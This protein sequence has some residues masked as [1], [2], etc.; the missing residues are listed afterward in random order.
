LAESGDL[1]SIRDMC[2][3]ERGGA[4]AH[5]G[6]LFQDHI[7][8][9]FCLEMLE[10]SSLREVWCESQDDITLF[11]AGGP[12]ETVEFVQV[13]SEEMDQLWSIA[14][15]CSR[16]SGKAGTSIVERSLAYDRPALEERRFRLVTA[17]DVTGELEIL[18][19]PLNSRHRSEHKDVIEGITAQIAARLGDCKSPAG[20]G[21]DFWLQRLF[22]EVQHDANVVKQA[23]S[24]R[25]RGASETGGDY[26]MRDQVG[27]V[28]AQLLSRVSE[29][30]AAVWDTDREKKTISGKLFSKWFVD[31]IRRVAHPAIAGTGVMLR[32][33]METAGIADDYLE[34]AQRLRRAYRRE[35]LNPKYLCTSDVDLIEN[36]VLASLNGLKSQLDG[37]SLEDKGPQFHARCISTLSELRDG[38]VVTPAPLLSF[39]QGCMYNMVDRCPHRFSRTLP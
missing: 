35:T 22:W 37:G 8:A 36:E 20:N 19:S 27:E 4:V 29:A 3:L 28:Y 7:A 14:K 24:E 6:L 17:R 34:T 18:K 21:C 1:K 9:K 15:L 30:A 38:I 5:K 12:C 31:V 23:N 25:L 26:L 10:D 2:P 11:W 39:L 16:E 13:K 32:Q 33:K